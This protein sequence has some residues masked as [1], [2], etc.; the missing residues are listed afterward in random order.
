M[1]VVL[2]AA[3]LVAG[4]PAQNT[5]VRSSAAIPAAAKSQLVN[6]APKR[7][8]GASCL[9]SAKRVAGK[10][11]PARCVEAQAT[12]TVSLATWNAMSNFAVPMVGAAVGSFVVT[13]VV[14]DNKGNQTIVISSR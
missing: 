13:E 2:A 1:L 5:S 3:G 9:A 4:A 8:L 6:T 11:A 12:Q 10:N 14:N 7:N